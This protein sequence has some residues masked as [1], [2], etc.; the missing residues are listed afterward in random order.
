MAAWDSTRIMGQDAKADEFFPCRLGCGA[1]CVCISISSPL[2][3]H[4][5]GK[6]GGVRCANLTDDNLCAIFGRPERP[7]VCDGFKA[8]RLFCGDSNEEAV[9]ILS[10]LEASIGR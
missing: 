9:R 5:N 4:P 2:P 8:E 1:C 10:E 3:G 6:P 7:A